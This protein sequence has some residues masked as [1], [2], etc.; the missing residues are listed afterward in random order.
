MLR[1]L[2]KEPIPL[3]VYV[4]HKKDELRVLRKRFTIQYI[5]ISPHRIYTDHCR[6]GQITHRPYLHTIAYR[7]PRFF[8][9]DPKLIG[10]RKFLDL[11]NPNIHSTQPTIA[12]ASTANSCVIGTYIA[13]SFFF[14]FTPSQV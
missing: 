2:S 12:D 11:T 8:F 4:G 1:I 9:V 3:C 14:F 6:L 7:P 10:C 5:N 13:E